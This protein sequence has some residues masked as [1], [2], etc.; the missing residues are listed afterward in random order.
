M[1]LKNIITTLILAFSFVY[2]F[3]QNFLVPT[4]GFSMKKTAYVTLMDGSE[5]SGQFRGGTMVNGVYKS[6]TLKEEDGTKHKW[7]P[8][9][10]ESMLIP[11]SKMAKVDQASKNMSKASKWKDDSSLN[12]AAL[13]EGYILYEGVTVTKK[14][15][16]QT[17][18]LQ[19]LNPA[20]ASKIK[21]YHNSMSR[22]TAGPSIGGIKLAGGDARTYYVKKGD[23]NAEKFGKPKY[24]ENYTTLFGDCEAFVEKFGADIRWAAF[25]EHV[26]FYDTECKE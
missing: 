17:V 18:L 10:I 6:V 14:K 2:S 13:K 25:Q 12:E 26:Y 19:L 4:D 24:Q 15:K 20:Y 8:E 5:F 9:E 16:E 11:L 3:G 23:A 22:E 1:K 21:V 7:K